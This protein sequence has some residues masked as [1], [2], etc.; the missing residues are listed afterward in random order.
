[1]SFIS[2]LQASM[3]STQVLTDASIAHQDRVNVAT[4]LH[5]VDVQQQLVSMGVEPNLVLARVDSMSDN[6][7]RELAG[8]IEQKPAGS[9]ILGL[10]GFVLVVLLIT[11]LLKL[12]NIY[13]F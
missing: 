9:G 11:D 4:A 12:T 1:M 2:T 10:L 8:L 5:R 6:E 7:I 13:N 3:L